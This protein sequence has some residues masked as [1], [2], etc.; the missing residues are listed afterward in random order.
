M[1]NQKQNLN[2]RHI[3]S[4]NKNEKQKS[5]VNGKEKG[6]GTSEKSF[7]SKIKQG[8]ANF[9]KQ[10]TK[11]TPYIIGTI[12]GC[13]LL[14]IMY[15]SAKYLP[16][17]KSQNYIAIMKS[18]DENPIFIMIPLAWVAPLFEE[19]ICRKLIFG[20]L[21]K[22]SLILAYLLSSFV[23]T[24]GHYQFN[25]FNLINEINSTPTYFISGLILA[26]SYNHTGYLLT[27]VFQ[28]YVL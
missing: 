16:F 19:F 14:L 25:I 26:Y 13:I 4:Q 9:G 21:K 12:V 8:I 27:N 2:K 15:L 5:K 3:K 28:F 24:I 6:K 7:F 18:I 10:F 20:S 22:H 23:F 17:G 11:P 1:V